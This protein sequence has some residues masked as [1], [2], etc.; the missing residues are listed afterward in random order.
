MVYVIPQV[1]AYNIGD[2]QRAHTGFDSVL[3]KVERNPVLVLNLVGAG[4]A[5]ATA[6]GISAFT[7]GSRI[8]SQRD[9]EL[10]HVQ[11][12]EPSGLPHT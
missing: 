2:E 3:I 7:V 9:L 12:G 6:T 10:G 5:N 8:S 11:A 4:T 1:Y